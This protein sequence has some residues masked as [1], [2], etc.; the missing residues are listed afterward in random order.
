MLKY[1]A[2]IQF[3]F[4]A[5]EKIIYCV[6]VS[7]VLANRQLVELKDTFIAVKRVATTSKK[8]VGSRSGTGNRP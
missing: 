3:H 1:T 7:R 6:I 4:A 5:V 2:C 8:I